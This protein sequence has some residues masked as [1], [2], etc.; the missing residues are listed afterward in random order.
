MKNKKTI[1][2]YIDTNVLVNYCTCQKN[3]VDALNYIFSKRRKEVLF[4]S[5]L[6]LAQTA[7][8]LQSGRKT[9]KKFSKD[10]VYHYFDKFLRKISVIEVSGNDILSAKSANGNDV[11]DNIHY[12]LSKKVKC[13]AIVTNNIKDF[14]SFDNIM[15]IPPFLSFVKSEIV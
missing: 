11:E 12:I 10:E 7:A 14:S 6:A 13:D 1:R 4:T 15:T 3:D 8:T 2:L 5:S 9:R